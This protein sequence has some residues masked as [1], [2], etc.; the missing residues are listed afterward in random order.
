MP[1]KKKQNRRKRNTKTTTNIVVNNAKM[2]KSK[3]KKTTKPRNRNKNRS[4]KPNRNNGQIHRERGTIYFGPLNADGT[5][6]LS[7][8]TNPVLFTRN[9]E[10]S[11]YTGTG[12]AL[13]SKRWER[14]LFKKCQ[15]RFESTLP[16][17]MG[18]QFVAYFDTDPLD[19]PT[20][21]GN[22]DHV[23]RA[24]MENAKAQKFRITSSGKVRCPRNYQFKN[25]RVGRMNETLTT[26][27]IQAKLWVIQTA[28]VVNFNGVLV[29]TQLGQIQIGN[30][31]LD[32]DV[33]FYVR[34][35]VE[36]ET[37][38]QDSLR[39]STVLGSDKQPGA[40]GAV[41]ASAVRTWTWST[42]MT[43]VQEEDSDS[44]SFLGLGSG[45]Y[46]KWTFLGETSFNRAGLY[47]SNTTVNGAVWTNTS[48]PCA[49]I[50]DPTAFFL[51]LKKFGAD[52]S[53]IILRSTSSFSWQSS[54]QILTACTSL[55]SGGWN[56][57][58]EN[59]YQRVL[60]DEWIY[61]PS[62]PMLAMANFQKKQDEQYQMLTA[63]MHKFHLT[64]NNEEEQQQFD[65]ED[66]TTSDDTDS[67]SDEDE[68]TPL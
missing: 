11:G 9:I 18:G 24:A 22:Y 3:K 64:T 17:T 5:T 56:Q 13:E 63:L 35:G 45:V 58:A 19:D 44:Y 1:P 42:V 8:S 14:Y 26:E 30:L 34:Q 66:D 31:W 20:A 12:L 6:F 47:R 55:S 25:F 41:S 43:M 54:W 23:K 68:I 7:P 51:F 49:G 4:K 33:E 61:A 16:Q 36:N 67:S 39:A 40:Y 65:S 59:S 48:V 28:A 15:V 38:N 2:Q 27:H 62:G 29:D 60:S 50:V 46:W 21:Q 10:P 53:A 52:W 32:Y 37:S 57:F